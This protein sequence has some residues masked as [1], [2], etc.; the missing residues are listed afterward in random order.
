ML[1]YYVK[2]QF[3]CGSKECRLCEL[4]FSPLHLQQIHL[5]YSA[6]SYIVIPFSIVGGLHIR[7]HYVASSCAFYLGSRA[8]D[9]SM[10]TGID[11]CPFGSFNFLIRSL[12]VS[13]LFQ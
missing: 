13:H 2:Q 11:R 5:S 1:Q 8:G 3:G 9:E 12:H 7:Y 10:T 4:F 6:L